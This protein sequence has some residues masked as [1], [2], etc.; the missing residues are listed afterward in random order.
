M[1]IFQDNRKLRCRIEDFSIIEEHCIRYFLK[2]VSY[3]II[4]TI[5]DKKTFQFYKKDEFKEFISLYQREYDHR[6]F[7]VKWN[8][9]EYDHLFDENGKLKPIGG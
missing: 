4:L 5:F 3:T 8:N 2:K 1:I 7:M 6:E 9:G